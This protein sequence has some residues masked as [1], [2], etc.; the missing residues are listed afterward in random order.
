M[1]IPLFRDRGRGEARKAK[2]S[3]REP[4][5]RSEGC[6]PGRDLRP[7]HQ[8]S[9]YMATHNGKLS[10]PEIDD[11]PLQN[12]SERLAGGAQTTYVRIGKLRGGG[13]MEGSEKVLHDI[14][15]EHVSGK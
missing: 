12:R 15:L 7:L 5:L 13:G 6:C 4:S 1:V 10:D 8:N 3:W 2:S 14:I 11:Q 9:K